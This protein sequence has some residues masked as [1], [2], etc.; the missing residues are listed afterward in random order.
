MTIRVFVATGQPWRDHEPV[1]EHSIR[2]NTDA[3]VEIH[4]IDPERH[5]MGRMGCTGFTHVRFA[6]PELAGHEGFAIYLDIDMLVVGD[7][8]DLWA[9]RR[10]GKWMCLPDGS[11]EVSVIDC[12]LKFPPKKELQNYGKIKLLQIASPHRRRDIPADWNVEDQV[13]PGMK[14]L[15][16]TDLKQQPWLG[17]QH[18]DSEC[19]RLLRE[20]ENDYQAAQALGV[21]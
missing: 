3:E 16:F 19:L 13:R 12:R 9:W 6:V 17:H 21:A 2:K 11:T 14:L 15:H 4:F 10:I 7:I 8:R 1:L 5:G 18:K 20:Y